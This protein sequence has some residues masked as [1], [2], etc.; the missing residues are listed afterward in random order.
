MVLWCGDRN[1]AY[2]NLLYNNTGG[3]IGLDGGSTNGAAYSNTLYNNTV[4]GIGTSNSTGTIVK[5]NIIWAN[6]NTIN[7]TG[8]GLVESNNLCADCAIKSDPRFVNPAG[9]DFHLQ[10]GSPAI[11]AG[12]NLGSLYDIDYDGNPRPA[13]GAWTIGAYE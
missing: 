1:V 6:G 4:G 8:S 13:A 5:N 3:G 11:G 10:F 7:R 12:A 2:N 9:A